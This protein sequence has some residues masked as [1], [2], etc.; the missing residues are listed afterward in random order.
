MP[1]VADEQTVRVTGGLVRG[2]NPSE[3][4]NAARIRHAIDGQAPETTRVASGADSDCAP[5]ARDL[6][7][8]L[9][10]IY[11][12]PGG[13]EAALTEVLHRAR[14]AGTAAPLLLLVPDAPPLAA[15]LAR[16][17]GALA[18]LV[19]VLGDDLS[20]SDVEAAKMLGAEAAGGGPV[21]CA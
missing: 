6:P 15:V 19:C 18:D 14:E 9:R 11:G 5:L 8:E 10:G 12:R 3:L 4:R 17:R 7:V 13:Y 1:F 16:H 21:L 2:L 20:A